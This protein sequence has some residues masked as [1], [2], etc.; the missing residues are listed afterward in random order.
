MTTTT[1]AERI[2]DTPSTEDAGTRVLHVQV[3]ATLHNALKVKA[4]KADLTMG[5]VLTALL[6]RIL[7]DEAA[8][9]AL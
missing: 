2:T 5:A 8:G 1:S 7:S 6:S 4:A 3:P 9:G